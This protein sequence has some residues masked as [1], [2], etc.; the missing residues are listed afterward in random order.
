MTVSPQAIARESIETPVMTASGTFGYGKEFE[1]LVDLNRL[2]GII[3]KGL[4]LHPS[5]G[6]A[7]PRIIETPCGMLNAIGLENIGIEFAVQYTDAY[8]ESV[9]SFA[10]TINTVDGGTHL[11]GMRAALTRVVNDDSPPWTNWLWAWQNPHPERRLDGGDPV[12]PDRPDHRPLDL[13][14]QCAH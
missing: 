2:G 12:H 4:S 6:N 1:S 3:V 13:A 11:T 7:P 8:T 9:Y 10:N 5:K 14:D